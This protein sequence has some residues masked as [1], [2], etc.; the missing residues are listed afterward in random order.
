MVE[1]LGRI[2]RDMRTTVKAGLDTNY[3]EAFKY[4]AG[5]ILCSQTC[6]HLS[7]KK[8]LRKKV[9]RGTVESARICFLPWHERTCCQPCPNEK[10]NEQIKNLMETDDDDDDI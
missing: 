5:G 7:R 4:F 6:Q 10:V 9:R 2:L 1:R 3:G 8:S